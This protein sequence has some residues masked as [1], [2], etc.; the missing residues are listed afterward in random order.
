[1]NTVAP[2]PTA[3]EEFLRIAERDPAFVQ[4]EKAKS[5]LKR[6]GTPEDIANFVAFVA[7]DDAGWITG[8]LIDATGGSLLG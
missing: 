8:Q 7:S 6:L 1:M 3:T 5:A 4:H 2:D